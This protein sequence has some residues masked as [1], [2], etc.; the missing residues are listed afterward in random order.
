MRVRDDKKELRKVRFRDRDFRKA[1]G[2]LMRRICVM[3]AHK[4]GAIAVRDSKGSFKEDT[5][6]QREGVGCLRQGREGRRV[7]SVTQVPQPPQVRGKRNSASL[8]IYM[9]K[10]LKIR[11]SKKFS[12]YGKF[13]GSFNKPLFIVIHGLPGNMDEEFYRSAVRWFEKRGFSTFRFNLYDYRK[14]A[15]QLMDCTLKLH[16][17]DLDAVVRYFRKR[18]V[19]KIFVAGH[20]FGG[21]TIFSSRRQDFDGVALWDPSYKISFKKTAYGFSDGKYVKEINGYLMRWGV[22]VIIGKAMVEEVDS[23]PWDSIS[24]NFKSPFKIIIA[25]RGLLRGSKKYL[26]NAIVEKDLTTI[27]GAT[28]YFNDREGMQEKVFKISEEWFK[29]F[30]KINRK[31]LVI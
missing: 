17:S 30:M 6:L 18:G 13:N 1:K 16:G 12:L 5:H 4:D 15:R 11:L 22:S 8:Y 10:K 3:V 24:R 2:T 21:L 25:G 26:N 29:K 28:H 19:E 7:R 23:F 27:K 14:D 20:S 31:N 9:E